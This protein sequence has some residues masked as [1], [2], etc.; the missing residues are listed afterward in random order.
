MSISEDVTPQEHALGNVMFN[1]YAELSLSRRESV[2]TAGG[3][4]NSMLPPGWTM[5]GLHPSLVRQFEI[6][7]RQIINKRLV[8]KIWL[9]FALRRR[10]AL[11]SARTKDG[12]PSVMNCLRSSELFKTWPDTTLQLLVQGLTFCSYRKGDIVFHTGEGGQ[13]GIYIL[14]H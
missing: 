6:L 11:T 8:P 12:P 1:R 13:Q 2:D 4:A 14:T 10:A 3:A 5:K 7:A 9:R